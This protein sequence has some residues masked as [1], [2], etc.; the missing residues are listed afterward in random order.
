M[1]ILKVGAGKSGR[2]LETVWNGVEVLDNEREAQRVSCFPFLFGRREGGLGDG[3]LD[4]CRQRMSG[5]VWYLFWK[6]ESRGR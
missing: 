1:G 5:W 3:D 4:I 2:E 6:M